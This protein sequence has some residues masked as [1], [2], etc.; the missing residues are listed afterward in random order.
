MLFGK[1]HVRR[2][3]KTD[4]AEGYEWRKGTTILLLTT[5]GRRSGQART[6]PLIFRPYGEAYLIVASNGGSDQPP[7]W[8]LNLE[9]NPTVHVQIKGDRFVA[10][11]RTASPD[12]KPGMWHV[13]AQVWPDYDR[14]QKRTGREIPVVV[15][16]RVLTKIPV[17]AT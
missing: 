17:T 5:T 11:A 14:Y 10:H 12:E 4:G 16:D 6:T 1:E 8:Y 9:S 15:L 3:Q 2:Y 13:M 7:A